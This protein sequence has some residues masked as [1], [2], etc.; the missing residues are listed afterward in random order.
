MDDNNNN[1]NNKNNHNTSSQNWTPGW[2]LKQRTRPRQSNRSQ[3]QLG[4][5]RQWTSWRF[6]ESLKRADCAVSGSTGVGDADDVEG[7]LS[8]QR[9]AADDDNPLILLADEAIV[10]CELASHVDGFRRAHGPGAV[11]VD[12]GGERLRGWV[13]RGIDAAVEG[14]KARRLKA[15]ADGQ[16]GHRGAELHEPLDGPPGGREADDRFGPHALGQGH[17]RGQD[18]VPGG[19][20]RRTKRRREANLPLQPTTFGLQALARLLPLRRHDDSALHLHALEGV[21]ADG[22]LAAEHDSVA[23]VQDGVRDVTALGSGR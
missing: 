2:E 3:H 19:N 15:G 20:V 1:N 23:A 13:A 21:L 8:E 7:P 16:H 10:A 4:A 12:S 22:T 17:S 18:C 5:K 14:E 6:Q 9:Q 11:G